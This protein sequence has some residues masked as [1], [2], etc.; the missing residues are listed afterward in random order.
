MDYNINDCKSVLSN[1][2]YDKTKEGTNWVSRIRVKTEYN[3]YNARDDHIQKEEVL[4][5][6]LAPRSM[7][8]SLANSPW[9]L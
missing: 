3:E 4:E 5:V 2:D 6:F 1:I 7:N 9:S 8:N